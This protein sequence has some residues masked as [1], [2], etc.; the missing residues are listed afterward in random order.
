M[1]H[2]PVLWEF[3]GQS[4]QK[5]SLKAM[6]SERWKYT[7]VTFVYFGII[8]VVHGLDISTLPKS[9]ILVREFAIRMGPRK[10]LSYWQGWNSPIHSGSY[11]S[12]VICWLA[13]A[14]STKSNRYAS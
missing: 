10:S 6:L 5:P 2:W 13:G 7:D 4:S 14:D 3:D 9:G 8:V 12:V 11:R 1:P